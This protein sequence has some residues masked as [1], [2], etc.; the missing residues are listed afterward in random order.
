MPFK[1]YKE[2]HGGKGP[3]KDFY[4]RATNGEGLFGRLDMKQERAMTDQLIAD[5]SGNAEFR[6]LE[7]IL[8]IGRAPLTREQHTEFRSAV[9]QN[10]LNQRVF[11]AG[12][13]EYLDES[14][15]VRANAISKDDLLMLDDMD[16]QAKHAQRL[17]LSG[18]EALRQ[19]G[20]ALMANVLT[21][22]REYLRTN[23]AQR[24]ELE[25]SEEAQRETV[26]KE[27]QG[28][29]N[30]RIFDP[31]RQDTA[32]YKSIR[33][34]LQGAGE[35]VAPQALISAVL[36]YTGAQLRQSDDGNWSFSLGPLGFSDP[37][38]PAMTFSQL[39]NRLDQA[40]QGRDEFMRGEAEGYA[41]EAKKRG[42]GINGTRVNDLMFPLANAAYIERE[43]ETQAT[44]VKTDPAK[45]EAA[46][47]TALDK[48]SGALSGFGRA[49]MPHLVEGAG[50]AL[51]WLTPDPPAPARNR[52][53]YRGT[54]RRPTN[55]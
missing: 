14:A 11:N 12:Y 6:G 21:T 46:T 52:G 45:V 4:S 50:A 36:E 24:L 8:E 1:K 16:A 43:Q 18:D 32:N 35:E 49:A 29:L 23:E 54:I 15:K 51:D 31:I 17:S 40:Y 42:F 20:M 38:V 39:R 27:I 30:S 47:R 44:E 5:I 55:E 9:M 41:A 7:G 48:V 34:Q 3:V 33:A 19:Q 25:S 10:A 13:Q 26:R 53:P 37:N 2:A 28:E 22:R